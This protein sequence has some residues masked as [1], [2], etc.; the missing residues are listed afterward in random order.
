MKKTE[1]EVGNARVGV[2]NLPEEAIED[3]DLESVLVATVV[4]VR[5]ADVVGAGGIKARE[6]KDKF[7]ETEEEG[8]DDVVDC[9]FVL[10]GLEEKGSEASMLIDEE[11]VDAEVECATKDQ[12]CEVSTAI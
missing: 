8:M 12:V 2:T 5:G 9:A 4:R 7:G 6:E 1:G 10:R 3:C 11:C